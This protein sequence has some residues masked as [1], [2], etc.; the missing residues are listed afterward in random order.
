MSEGAE[1]Q[2]TVRKVYDIKVTCTSCGLVI[3][4]NN[5]EVARLAGELHGAQHE[6]KMWKGVAFDRGG[7]N[8]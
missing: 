7:R 6:L 1:I 4:T 2:V 5:A 8:G 3:E